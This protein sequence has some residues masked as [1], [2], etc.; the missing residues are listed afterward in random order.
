VAVTALP[1]GPD[2]ATHRPWPSSA[3]TIDALLR[4]RASLPDT[5]PDRLLLR[6]QVIEAALPRVRNMARRYAGRGEPLDDLEQV[7][8]LGLLKAVDG[9]DPA[10]QAGFWA[11]ATPTVLGNLKR[12]FRDTGWAVD[13]PRRYKDLQQQVSRCRDELAQ[14]L[15]RPPVLSELSERLGKD[16]EEVARALTAEKGYTSASLFA[17]I[18]YQG[19]ASVADML[20]EVEPGFERVDLQ[21][22]IRP[23]LARLPYRER[24][25]IALRYFGNMTQAAIAAQLRVSQ[26]HVSRSLARSLRQLRE[27]LTQEAGHEDLPVV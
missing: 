18:K 1:S 8:A 14:R 15:R 9:F 25:I 17:P 11:Y 12:H 2:V 5:H 26:M 21:E 24:H 20:G 16:Q 23:A 7:A 19:D 10:H 3:T 27:S 13:V 6:R 4:Q 22:S